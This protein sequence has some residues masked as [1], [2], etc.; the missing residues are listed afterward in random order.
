M[1]LVVVYV[2]D[3]LRRD[4]L[5]CYGYHRRTSPHIDELAADSVVFEQAY[6]ESTWTR[7]SA[8]SLLTSLYPLTHGVIRQS[9][10]LPAGLQTLPGIMRDNAY[11]TIGISAM[12][13]VSNRMGFGNGFDTFVDLYKDTCIVRRRGVA[14]PRPMFHLV[15]ETAQAADP[16][17]EDINERLFELLE[18]SLSHGPVFAFAWSIETHD[19]YD[20]PEE[21]AVFLSANS[22]SRRRVSNE[23][24]RH[25]RTAQE[26][27]NIRDLYDC[28]IHANDR[29]IGELLRWLRDH[30]AYDSSLIVITADHGEAFGEHGENGHS[31]RPYD[32]KI[33]IPLIIKFP[34]QKWA[35]RRI[36]SF[37]QLLDIAPTVLDQAGIEPPSWWQGRSL[38]EVLTHR[39]SGRLAVCS[40]FGILD[41]HPEITG[42][43]TAWHKIIDVSHPARGGTRRVARRALDALM[44]RAPLLFDLRRDSGE[45]NSI[46][47]R[48]APLLHMG[49]MTALM[50]W[51]ARCALLRARMDLPDDQSVRIEDDAQLLQQL[52]H[53]GYV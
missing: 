5:S 51:R 15:G 25:S 32:E 39:R 14:P 21:D 44:P 7:P 17:S 50:A 20:P 38:R 37:A 26:M 46:S 1:P 45:H 10:G 36:H 40:H 12:G 6:S 41:G 33:A 23:E 30:R 47:V 16:R 49:M 35:G 11:R 2:C 28:E 29:S 48:R 53:L 43:R 13:N 9:D 42:Y 18:G 3:S 52:E 31:G 19:P 34:G 22:G 24:I 4:H 8:A 27:R